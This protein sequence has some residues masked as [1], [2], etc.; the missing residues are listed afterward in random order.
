VDPADRRYRGG[1]KTR[2]G[3]PALRESG[4]RIPSHPLVKP[5]KLA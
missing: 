4:R 1:N 5:P 3:L 2:H